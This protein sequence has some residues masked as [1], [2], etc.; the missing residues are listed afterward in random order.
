MQAFV[1]ETSPILGKT[2]QL[3]MMFDVLIAL[4]PLV[5]FAIYKFKIDAVLRIVLQ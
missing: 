2:H 4:I 3:R 5:I 1:K